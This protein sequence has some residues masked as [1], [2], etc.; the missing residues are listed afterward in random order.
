MDKNFKFSLLHLLV[1]SSMTCY[2]TPEEEAA[3]L[4]AKADADEIKKKADEDAKK[5]SDK[6]MAA[7]RYGF[8]KEL[9]K[10][11]NEKLKM[12]EDKRL[13]AEERDAAAKRAEELQSMYLTEKET[14]AQKQKKMEDEH[15]TK[16]KAAQ[17]EVKVYKGK[18]AT[19]LIDAEL[20]TE[21]SAA[22]EE[23]PGTLKKYLKPDTVLVDE[24]DGQGNPTGNQVVRV[25][26]EDTDAAGKPVKLVLS[27]KDTLK[28]MK[29]LPAQHGIFFKGMGASGLGGYNGK[30]GN[31]GN[32][33]P[34]TDTAAYIAN[35]KAKNAKP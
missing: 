30:G 8:K 13:T 35:R 15:N 25:N 3:A 29:E 1:V 17:E 20:A 10:E 7:A 21:I 33:G 12:A 19:T 2:G 24:L 4:K 26:F 32:S 31:G 11:V 5:F 18:Y 28:R 6:D 22:G 23:I 16:L 14:A 27:V 9:E 34:I